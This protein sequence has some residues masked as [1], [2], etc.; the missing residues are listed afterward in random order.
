LARRDS[1]PGREDAV[2]S[3]QMVDRDRPAV[4]LT[5]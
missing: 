1:D 4:A 2:Q 5:A 3:G